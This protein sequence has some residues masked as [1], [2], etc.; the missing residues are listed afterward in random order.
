M[1]SWRIFLSMLALFAASVLS[2]HPAAAAPQILALVASNGIATP[3]TCQNG[4]CEAELSS[5][6]LQQTRATPTLGTVYHAVAPA[7]LTLSVEKADGTVRRVPFGDRLSLTAKRGSTS[8]KASLAQSA[9]AGFGN[10][11]LS[12]LVAKRVSLIPEAVPGAKNPLSKPEIALAPSSLRAVGSRVV[13]RGA[14]RIA[15]ARATNQLI[16][17]I[18]DPAQAETAAGRKDVWDR[19]TAYKAPFGIGNF[20]ANQTI[21]GCASRPAGT[22][23]RQCLREWHDFLMRDLNDDYWDHAQAGS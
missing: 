9:V 10:A 15:A 2:A 13:D 22:P 5:F 20:W 6:C 3:L 18:S 4:T 12:I 7:D 1:A 14:R 21:K 8:V 19:I 16:N 17:A 23:M 11:K